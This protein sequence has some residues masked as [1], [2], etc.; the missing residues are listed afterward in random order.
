VSSRS[1]VA[2]RVDARLDSDP[3]RV[4]SR[5][6]LPGE[7]VHSGRSRAAVVVARVLALPEDEVERI[8]AKLLDEF[9]SRHRD[10]AAVLVEHA[11]TVGAH[12]ANSAPM[13][14]AR[15]LVMGASFTAEYAVEGAALCNPSAVLHPD[16]RDL[17]PR[18]VR[19]AVSLRGIGEGHHSSIAFASAVLS[20][21]PCWTF[22]PRE[23]PVV[24]GL[25]T[26]SHWQR[27]YLRAVL[28]D[29]G[30]ID[31]LTHSVLA[32]LPDV[33]TSADLQAALAH[34]HRDLHTRAGGT[35]S[36][37]LLRQLVASAYEVSFPAD[38]ALSQQVLLPSSADESDGM[39]DA[40]FLRFVADDGTVEYRATYTAYDGRHIASRLLTSPDLRV[41]RAYRL[42]GPAARNKGM[43]LFPR[44]VHG[45]HLA[46]CRFDG[47]T[48]SLASS[49]D[50]YV[51]GTPER[52]QV[53]EASWEVLQIGNCGPPIETDAGWLVLTHGVG[54]MR[55][56]AI[57]A[58]LLDLDDPTR[59]LGRL[60]QPLLRPARDE[61]DGHVPN[62]VYSCGGIV[63]DGVLWL[64][65]GI[66]DRRIGV[67]WISLRELLAEMAPARVGEP[68]TL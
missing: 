66:G 23:S 20:P 40:R 34:L 48:T 27:E 18:S 56:Y 13:S 49:V 38:V 6:F 29:R 46:L 45:R 60:R 54:P 25:S 11:A 24:A 2:H 17:P 57:G 30:A 43:A 39:E 59:V 3:G 1:P 28:L 19:V 16:Q 26:G 42:A 53:P 37:A 36:V 47:E 52:I 62:V 22:E 32:G 63:H 67:A 50:G 58:M 14:A 21:G 68:I 41:F 51:W 8:A 12:L 5:L 7:E 44:L 10:Y 64:P 9:S 33:F 55:T 35:A 15:T 31:E 65:Y 61:R 4:V